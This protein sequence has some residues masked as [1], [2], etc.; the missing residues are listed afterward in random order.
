MGRLP[1]GLPT[2]LNIGQPTGSRMT[3][4]PHKKSP[5]QEILSIVEGM[6]GTTEEI[7]K[8]KRTKEIMDVIMK[9]GDLSSIQDQQPEP[10]GSTL[11]KILQ[12]ITAPFDP[13]RAPM[14]PVP[15][16]ET[17][18]ETMAGTMVKQKMTPKRP[19]TQK[20]DNVLYQYDHE[21]GQWMPVVKGEQ[22]MKS[23]SDGELFTL[24]ARFAPG[25]IEPEP[26]ENL[27]FDSVK[28]EMQLRKLYPIEQ[29]FSPEQEETIKANMDHYRK[30]REEVIDALRKRGILK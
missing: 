29:K 27:V 10:A 26:K 18:A 23:F 8:Q 14:G 20:I 6:A 1:T 9:G 28:E 30:S 21:T 13:R 12:G 17:I 15:L 3:Y 4:S 2:S 22:G 24:Y 19:V 5:L 16:E 25:G 7:R 11:G